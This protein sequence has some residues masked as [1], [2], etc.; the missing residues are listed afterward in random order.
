[1]IYTIV[2]QKSW[3]GLTSLFVK[4]LR[5]HGQ[6]DGPI[7]IFTDGELPDRDY[8]LSNAVSGTVHIEPIEPSNRWRGDDSFANI[9]LLRYTLGN[10]LAEQYGVE[11]LAHFDVDSIA[12]RPIAP[13]IPTSSK[14]LLVQD[15]GRSATKQARD[16]RW[17]RGF[18]NE[19]E[20]RTADMPPINAGHFFGKLKPFMA[21]CQACEYIMCKETHRNAKPGVHDQSA[22]NTWALRCK[23]MWDFVPYG[24]IQGGTEDGV[25]PEARVV[26]TFHYGLKDMGPIFFGGPY[27]I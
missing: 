11:W 3:R 1:M 16:S 2:S 17:H 19:E 21:M 26:H 7:V 9:G 5:T 14:V 4:S 10:R 18:F 12:V 13:L 20:L 23:D 24:V 22:L 25:K 27:G 8:E 6:Y 15:A